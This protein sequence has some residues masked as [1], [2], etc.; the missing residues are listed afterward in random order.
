MSTAEPGRVVI[1]GGSGFVGSWVCETLVGRGVDVVCVD[2]FCTGRPRNV[3]HLLDEPGFELVNCDVSTGLDIEGPIDWVLH[4]ASP[5]SPPHYLRL[6]IETL[7]VGSVGTMNALELARRADARFLM[8]STS[9]V[10]GDPL[11]HPQRESYWGNVNPVGPRAVYD[12][13][14]RFSEALTVAY[15]ST[16]DMD[17]AIVRIFNTYGPRM[18]PDDGR[19]IPTFLHQAMAGEPITVAGDGSQTRS[20]CYIDDTVAGIMALAASREPGPV[21]IGNPDEMT[22]LE[23][24]ERIKTLLHS[25]SP[26]EFVELPTDDPKVRCPDTTLAEQLLGWSPR[27]S[28]AD[29]LAKTIEWFRAQAA[30][31]GESRD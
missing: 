18:R 12:E 26:I 11:E 15:R 9:E 19:A 16:Y 10:Y 8:A 22:M 30:S 20:I 7:R 21:N 25:A 27:V 4:L 14:K 1:T 23:L 29:G 5:A 17:T 3:S 6:P 2:N 31:D 24:A 28:A 13:A